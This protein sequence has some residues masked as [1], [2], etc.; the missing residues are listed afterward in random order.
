VT[1][2][3]NVLTET[4]APQQ[5]SVR[6]HGVEAVTASVAQHVRALRLARG[7]SLDELSGRSGV[8]KG[9]VVQIEGARTNPSVGTLCRLADAFGV[10]VARLLEPAADRTVRVTRADDAPMLWRG[11]YGG[12]ARLLGGLNEPDFVELWE[13]RLSPHDRHESP[14]HAPG[15]RE[16]LHVLAGRL[17]VT[18][19]GTEHLIQ[20]GETM[21]F[22]ADKAHSYRNDG[23]EP[24]RLMMVVVM[25]PGDFD[26]RRRG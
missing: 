4:P 15:T 22:Q 21:D 14:D 19:D 10:T 25:P 5:P 24:V 17:T 2:E 11:G 1:V 20:A 12:F 16:L 7:W 9:M 23:D 6:S 18:V 13:W 26:R 8:S 3:D